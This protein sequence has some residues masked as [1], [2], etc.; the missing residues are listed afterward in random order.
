MERDTIAEVEIDATGKLH[1]VPTKLAFQYI[2]REA[3]EVQWDDVRRS[4]HSPE[5]RAWSYARW[6]Q[7]IL[8]AAREQNCELS[9]AASTKWLNIDPGIKAEFLQVA[10]K[11]A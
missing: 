3:I 9:I 10:G 5:P 11:R 7:Q 1:V 6:F 2:Y 4:L 8:A